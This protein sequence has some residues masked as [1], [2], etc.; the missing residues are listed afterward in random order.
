MDLDDLQPPVRLQDRFGYVYHTVFKRPTD[1]KLFHYIGQHK[2]KKVDRHYIGSG[3]R[4]HQ[5]I[6]KYGL[7]HKLRV[8]V[9][10]WTSSRA[11]SDEKEKFFILEAKRLFGNA[12][13]NL[14]YGGDGGIMH[15]STRL[16]MSAARIGKRH[17]EETKRLIG[18]KS[19]GR[20]VGRTH[21]DEA[22][23]KI[24]AA[25]GHRG[26]W[27][28]TR[29][30]RLSEAL[31]GRKMPDSFKARMSEI[32]R[33]WNKINT[34]GRLYFNDGVQNFRLY[35]TDPRVRILKKGRITPWQ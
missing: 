10:A 5:M 17:S 9:T 32:R 15:E 18:A 29:K 3:H 35:V 23:R 13:L 16:K 1:G 20:N 2:S 27:S 8:F 33:S 31:R 19:K 14:S 28:D 30:K 21:T 26:P 25:N 34:R 24:S 4:L 12:C 11:E 6:R 22:K 7:V